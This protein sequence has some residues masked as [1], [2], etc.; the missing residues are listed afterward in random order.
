MRY[1]R[2]SQIYRQEIKSTMTIR[3]IPTEFPRGFD[4]CVG[5]PETTTTVPVGLLDTET[6]ASVVGWGSG[7]VAAASP[8]GLFCNGAA[9][10]V[11]EGAGGGAVVPPAVCSEAGAGTGGGSDS[12]EVPVLLAS[13]AAFDDIV[14]AAVELAALEEVASV[15]C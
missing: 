12:A 13:S 6:S 8:P 10:E 11:G 9:R 1:N 2:C 3:I 7:L 14:S 15:G 5:E 4:L